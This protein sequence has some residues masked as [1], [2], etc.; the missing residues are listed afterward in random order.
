MPDEAGGAVLAGVELNI[1]DVVVAGVV[2][3]L[4]PNRLEV[5]G[6]PVAVGLLAAPPNNELG[7]AVVAWEVGVL[8]AGVRPKRGLEPS[9]AVAG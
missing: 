6:V 4:L 2:V 8:V 1:L 7:A 5:A 9:G 3:G